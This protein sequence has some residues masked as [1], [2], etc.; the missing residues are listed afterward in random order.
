MHIT[1]YLVGQFKVYDMGN[2]LDVQSPRGNVSCDQ[3]PHLTLTKFLQ[4]LHSCGLRLV[5]VDRVCLDTNLI[6]VLDNFIGSVFCS[7][8]DECS[9]NA[10]ILQDGFKQGALI[11]PINK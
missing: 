8:E 1:F 9:F 4:C 11:L 10:F 2:T 6:Q 7:G 3:N 5:T